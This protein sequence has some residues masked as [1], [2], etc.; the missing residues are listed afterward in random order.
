[1]GALQFVA[2]VLEVWFSIVAA[3]LVYDLTML[4]ATQRKGVPIGYLLTHVEFGDIL[5]LF[6]S[7]ALQVFFIASGDLLSLCL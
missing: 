7:G 3:S 6:V 1:L 2:K 5:T 4:L